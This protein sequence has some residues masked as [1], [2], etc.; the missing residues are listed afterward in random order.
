MESGSRLRPLRETP[1]QTDTPN[2]VSMAEMGLHRESYS[3]GPLSS[4]SM[5]RR[6]SGIG[7]PP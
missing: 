1:S 4:P 6:T 2:S 7:G 3:G 5:A